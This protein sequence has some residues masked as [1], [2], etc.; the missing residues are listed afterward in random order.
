MDLNWIFKTFLVK[1]AY[2]TA[3]LSN[4][5]FQ[6]RHITRFDKIPRLIDTPR[7]TIQGFIVNTACN[8]FLDIFTQVRVVF[9]KTFY[10]ASRIF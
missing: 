7:H 3:Q 1:N 5:S 10:I 9:S 6:L 2:I 4:K 8:N